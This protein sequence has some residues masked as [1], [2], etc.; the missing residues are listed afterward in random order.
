MNLKLGFLLTFLAANASAIAV[1]KPE[2]SVGLNVGEDQKGSLGGIE[3]KVKWG[4]S[5]EVAGVGVEG[6]VEMTVQEI[7]QVPATNVWG[8][9]KKSFAGLGEVS[10]RGAM[11]AN[12]RD[13]VDLDVRANGF[14]TAVQVIGQASLNS[15]AVSKVQ[16]NKNVDVMGGTLRVNPKYD[17]AKAQPD[18]TLG[19]SMGNTNVQ[20]EAQK[21]K[22][23]VDHG[24]SDKDR[25]IPTVD[26]KGDVTLSY[27]RSL[28]GGRISTTWIPND[29]VQIRW[30]D[31]VYETTIKAP[32]D[33][34]FKAMRGLKVNMKRT[35][36]MF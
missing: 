27:T 21:Q 16:A 1:P 2:L 28:V 31:D 20:V 35:V 14:G 11:D 29:S 25:I 24:L 30:N 7:D 10:V 8:R 33:G 34:Y 17:V 23:T 12:A 4:T 22:L 9:L 36:D 15:I 18:V 3:P 6:G 13:T 19:Y 5:G 32:L 26:T